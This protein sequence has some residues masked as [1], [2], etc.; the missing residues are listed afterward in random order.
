MAVQFAIATAA[1]AEVIAQLV[2]ELTE[3]ICLRAKVPSFE[4]DVAGTVART[5][6]FLLQGVYTVILGWDGGQAVAVACMAESYALYAGGKIG[7]VQEFYVQPAHRS[8]GVGASLIAEVYALGKQR[9]WACVELC[10]PPLP[11]FSATIAFYQR[12]GL[13]PV[14]GRKMRVHL[15][16]LG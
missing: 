10:T 11:E 8:G 7:I 9:A 1:D 13:Q 16:A 15:H 12:H 4:L 5:R 6:A 3:E 14:G 2:L